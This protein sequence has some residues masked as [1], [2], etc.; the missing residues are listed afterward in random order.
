MITRG[1]NE[2]TISQRL[3]DLCYT[4]LRLQDKTEDGSFAKTITGRWWP[5][6]KSSNDTMMTFDRSNLNWHYWEW[7]ALPPSKLLIGIKDD[8]GSIFPEIILI[9]VLRLSD[10]KFAVSGGSK[11]GDGWLIHASTQGDLTAGAIKWD[12]SYSRY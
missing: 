10:G 3:P 5:T 9:G 12:V 8:S 4:T 11:E 6:D 1:Y 7:H 2:F